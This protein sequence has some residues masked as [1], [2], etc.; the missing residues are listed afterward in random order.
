MIFSSAEGTSPNITKQLRRC[1]R[2]LKTLVSLL[3]EKT[4]NLES[5]SW[6]SM[7]TNSRKCDDTEREHPRGQ[8]L[9]FLRRVPFLPT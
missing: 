4:V 6:I 1:C 7:D 9:F 8:F 3:I 2:E 5:M